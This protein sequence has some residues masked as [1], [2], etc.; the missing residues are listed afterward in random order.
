MDP[1][2]EEDFADRMLV[3]FDPLFDRNWGNWG[4]FSFDQDIWHLVVLRYAAPTAF[5]FK[6]KLLPCDGSG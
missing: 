5:T 1:T 6:Q 4:R 3:V 2:G